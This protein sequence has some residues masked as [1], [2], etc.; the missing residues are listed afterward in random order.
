MESDSY[1]I[2]IDVGGTNIRIGA[3]GSDHSIS[4]SEIIKKEKVLTSSNTV[5]QLAEFAQEFI[6]GKC[7]GMKISAIVIGVPAAVNR[8]KTTVLNA[9]NLR[10]FN[11]V[12]VVEIFRQYFQCPVYVEKDVNLL[13]R[14]D[15]QFLN[16]NLKQEQVIVG[17][18]IGTGIGNAVVINGSFLTGKNGVA[19]ELA[20]VPVM[21]KND[22]CPC[23]NFGCLDNYVSGRRLKR[24]QETYFPDTHI[25]D[26]FVCHRQ[27][28][29][30]IKYVERLAVAISIEVNLFD[31]DCLI[32]GG[33][34][35]HMHDFPRRDLEMRIRSHSRKPYPA[36]NLKIYYSSNTSIG[37]LIGARL[38]VDTLMSRAVATPDGIIAAAYDK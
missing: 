4:I 23:G 20:H 35:I 24:L 33:G 36:E 16:L 31:P 27:E 32:L 5:Y 29:L 8:Q 22:P 21:E 1:V 14:K 37:G 17:C 12:N 15:I 6:R 2:G 13:L 10:G 9:P 28:P 38:Y 30:I 34:V 19:C 11:G 25:S 3:V 7:A 18:Y 26:I